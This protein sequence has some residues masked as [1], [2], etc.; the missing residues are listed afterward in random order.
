MT[1]LEP[2]L[3]TGDFDVDGRF[4]WM[5][6]RFWGINLLKCP[7]SRVFSRLQSIIILQTIQGETI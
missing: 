5:K 2:P 7:P 6:D 1:R 3:S 4:K